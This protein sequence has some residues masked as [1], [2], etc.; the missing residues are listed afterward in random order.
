MKKKWWIPAFAAA[1]AVAAAVF[2]HF[3]GTVA[4]VPEFVFNYAENQS[5]DYPTTQ[6]AYYF[7]DL[8]K[9][10]TQG[11]IEILIHSG[12]QLG[13]ES[14]V[15]KQMRYGGVDFARVSISQ[16][17]ELVPDMNLLQLPYLY[18]DEDHMWR[19]LDSEI[20]A[21][22]LEIPADSELI[23]LSW[24][25]AGVRNFYTIDKPITCLEDLQGMVIRVQ[26]SAL[27]SDM[28]EAMGA[29]AARVPYG[30]VYSVLEQGAVDGA[31]N[32]WPSYASMR[33]YEVAKYYTLDEH[34][35]VPEMQIISQHTW[36]KLSAEDQE[37]IRACAQ[38]SALFERRL[39]D[40]R[41]SEAREKAVAAG[42]QIIEISD[43]E[44][45]RFRN[46][47]SEVYNKYAKEHADFIKQIEEKGEEECS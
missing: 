30:D 16:L 13:P 22:F 47:M 11:R 7:A 44:K 15:L 26:E 17:A 18:R 33:H 25:G 37:I 41:V 9:E 36:D 32:N 40:E 35:R 20:G 8:V 12:A 19:V 21:H 6:G 23:G 43:E 14:E 31:E 46:A 28:V 45:E 10:R 1:A 34:A 42:T 2:W 38:E 4:A 27:M 3:R 5:E 24:Y 39:W 29:T